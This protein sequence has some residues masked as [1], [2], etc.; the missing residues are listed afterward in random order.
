[1]QP[2][3]V[4]RQEFE[5]ER[6]GTQTLIANLDVA[7]GQIVAPSIGPTRT[8][9]DFAA[10]IAQTIQSDPQAAWIFVTDQL[11]THQSEALVRLVATQCGIQEDLGVKGKSGHLASMKTRAAFLSDP[12]HR[13]RMVYTPKHSSWLNQ[14][15]IWWS[16]LVRRLLARASWTSVTHLR[17][18]I[19]AFIAYSNR[20]SNGP[21]HWTYKGPSRS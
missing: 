19:L 1:M 11:N 7:S 12:S 15:E 4:E 8:E 3:H 10:H 2:G 17:E 13:L 16:H 9:A 20:L 21:F 18:G 6:H 14:I 5:D